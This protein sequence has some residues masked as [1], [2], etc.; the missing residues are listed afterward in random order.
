MYLPVPISGG[1]MHA[2]DALRGRGVWDAWRRLDGSQWWDAE[3]MAELQAEKL[4]HRVRDAARRSPLWARR[5]ADLGVDPATIRQ[6]AD[7][8]RL[9]VLERADLQD[10]FAEL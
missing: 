5:L 7:L 8:A 6:P 3:R 2:A 10:R 9:P 1:L 4:A